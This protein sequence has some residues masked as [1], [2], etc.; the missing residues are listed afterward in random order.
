MNTVEA[1]Y[2]EGRQKGAR[3]PDSLRVCFFIA[4]WSLCLAG[5]SSSAPTRSTLPETNTGFNDLSLGLYRFEANSSEVADVE[6]DLVPMRL[7]EEIQ[8]DETWGAVYRLPTS[9]ALADVRMLIHARKREIIEKE[10]AG[11]LEFVLGQ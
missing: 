4:L 10:C 8:K 11:L 9:D 1:R 6:R 3:L 7:L 5:C 2:P